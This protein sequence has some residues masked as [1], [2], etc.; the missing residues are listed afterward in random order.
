[1]LARI[2]RM[3]KASRERGASAVEYGLMVAAIAALI[4]G[5][6]FGLGQLVRNAFSTTSSSM[7]KCTSGGC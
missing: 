4:I 2:R 7:S 1:M 6:V 3:A 5:V